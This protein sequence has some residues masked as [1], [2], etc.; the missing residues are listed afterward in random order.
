[1]APA[2]SFC[3]HGPTDNATKCLLIIKK[4]G[5]DLS[6][7]T[8]IS[9]YDKYIHVIDTPPQTFS[10]IPIIISYLDLAM[11]HPNSGIGGK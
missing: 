9:Y 1:M 3:L 4:A 7:D 10:N 6:A 5:Y 8:Q 2:P 11:R